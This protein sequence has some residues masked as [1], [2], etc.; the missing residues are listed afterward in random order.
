MLNKLNAGVERN[1]VADKRSEDM[2]TPDIEQIVALNE[3]LIGM[4]PDHKKN[5]KS[6]I[7]AREA[8]NKRLSHGKTHHPKTMIQIE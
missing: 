4:P 8:R 1:K 3:E 7:M 5:S 6:G 2:V